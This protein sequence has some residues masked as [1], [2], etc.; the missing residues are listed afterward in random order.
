MVRWSI[1]IDYRGLLQFELQAY[2]RNRNSTV[3]WCL[4]LENNFARIPPLISG[5]VKIC[6]HAANVTKSAQR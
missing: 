4:H 6:L 3:E 2:Y 1:K 5:S